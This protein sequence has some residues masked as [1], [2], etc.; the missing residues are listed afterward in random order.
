[1][2]DSELILRSDALKESYLL[3]R[4]YPIL[5]LSEQEAERHLTETLTLAQKQI[6]VFG[7]DWRQTADQKKAIERVWKLINLGL[8]YA[9]KK[10]IKKDSEIFD[11]DLA[12]KILLKKPFSD[13]YNVGEHLFSTN[14]D[15]ANS[16]LAKAEIEIK[17][18]YFRLISANEYETLLSLANLDFCRGTLKEHRL[19]VNLAVKMERLFGLI[20]YLPLTDQS[21]LLIK[22]FGS[23]Q[24][25]VYMEEEGLITICLLSLII[26][27]FFREERELVFERE[28]LKVMKNFSAAYQEGDQKSLEVLTNALEAISHVN[29]EREYEGSHATLRQRFLLNFLAVSPEE[30]A[31]FSDLLYFEPEKFGER[32]KNI[33]RMFAGYFLLALKSLRLNEPQNFHQMLSYALDYIEKKVQEDV[34]AFYKT[35]KDPDPNGELVAKFW[36][37]RLIFSSQYTRAGLA[38]KGLALQMQ[39]SVDPLKLAKMPLAQIVEATT[40]F[41]GWANE[42]QEI[43]VREFNLNRLIWEGK[44]PDLLLAFLRNLSPRAQGWPTVENEKDLLA[45]SN[46]AIMV[47]T[48]QRDWLDLILNKL[49]WDHLHPYFVHEFWQQGCDQIRE[50]IYANRFKIKL[51][52]RALK[53]YY[54]AEHQDLRLFTYVLEKLIAEEKL[55]T[56]EAWQD[57]FFMAEEMPKVKTI[58][59]LVHKKWLAQKEKK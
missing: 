24:K 55:R 30:V 46:L 15:W 8:E 58:L 1:M 53:D 19:A 10:E 40:L 54:L 36:S 50:F 35:I 4:I 38:E 17:K 32:V 59:E 56:K 51:T 21:F 13:I 42:T 41:T 25:G 37:Q 7:G 12:K 20:P 28:N 52:L 39:E 43:F 29:K 26:A 33:E 11:I 23:P 57:L 14:K 47:Y 49:P 34:I 45:K 22:H 9:C 31:K 44:N 5:D 16:L 3:K 48:G 2:K 18:L 27:C 6:N